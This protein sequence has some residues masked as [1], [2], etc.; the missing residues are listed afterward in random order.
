MV[1][2]VGE[3]VLWRVAEPRVLQNTVDTRL[4]HGGLGDLGDMISLSSVAMRQQ[5]KEQGDKTKPPNLPK[6]P[7]RPLNTLRRSDPMIG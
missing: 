4:E 1:V 6:S 5:M 2:L 3:T 7:G